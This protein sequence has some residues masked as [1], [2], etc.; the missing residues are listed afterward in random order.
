MKD[1]QL[2]RVKVIN[3]PDDLPK[4]ERGSYVAHDKPGKRI[5]HHCK[6]NADFLKEFW[7]EN[8]DWYLEPIE[9]QKP[10]F[11]KAYLDECIK[12]AEHNLSK[13]KDVDKELAEIRGISKIT[14]TDVEAWA[15]KVAL[16][17]DEDDPC[18]ER[19]DSYVWEL[20]VKGAKAVLNGEIKHIK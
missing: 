6:Y 18:Y 4:G 15:D 3:G 19:I 9:E 2:L 11:D 1:G 5:Y 7:L 20:L 13:I 12:K 16:T 8:I 10:E 14:D 17:M